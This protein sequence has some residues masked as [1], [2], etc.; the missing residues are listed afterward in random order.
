M[1]YNQ[2]GKAVRRLHPQQLL[3]RTACCRHSRLQQRKTIVVWV[4]E[5]FLGW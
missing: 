2:I 3:K 5:G 1:G 4:I